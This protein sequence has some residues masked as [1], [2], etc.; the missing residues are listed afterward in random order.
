MQQQK[1]D[2]YTVKQ[3]TDRPSRNVGKYQPSQRNIAE[4]Q[5]SDFRRGGSLKSCT[6]RALFAVTLGP[7]FSVFSANVII[8]SLYREKFRMN[9]N[10][11][12]RK[13]V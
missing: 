12:A 2:C 1:Q 4:E 13:T 5:R 7:A 6:V 3:G 10:R 11:H 9:N 8:N